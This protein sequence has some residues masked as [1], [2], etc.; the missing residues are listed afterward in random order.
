ME[1]AVLPASAL[2]PL[3]PP[4]NE[5]ALI[6]AAQRGDVRAFNDLVRHYQ[7][8]AYRIAYRMMG[9]AALAG[10]VT[11]DAFA[12]AFR[13]IRRLDGS[14][15]L[16]LIQLVIRRCRERLDRP[17]NRTLEAA[18]MPGAAHDP[19]AQVQQALAAVP[20]DERVICI[21][22]DMEGLSYP[23]IARITGAAP[24]TLPRRLAHAR[25]RLR[26]VLVPQAQSVSVLF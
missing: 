11:Q 21:L 23:E 14:L 19:A 9:D 15:S 6:A 25:T 12:Y 2:S 7:G 17:A 13:Q 10:D 1:T 8:L 22:A 5:R 24:H 26:D 20:P 16:W 18:M 4:P 3:R